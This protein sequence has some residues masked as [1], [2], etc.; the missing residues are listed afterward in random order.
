MQTILLKVSLLKRKKADLYRKCKLKSSHPERP[1][2]T[3]MDSTSEF[4]K[5]FG[6]CWAAGTQILL[7][8]AGP[9]A[10]G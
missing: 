4:L 9:D 3:I 1:P 5:G 7:D 2:H 10:I 8:L 6:T